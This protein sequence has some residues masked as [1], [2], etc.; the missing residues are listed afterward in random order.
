MTRRWRGASAVGLLAGLA[1]VVSAC[2]GSSES[3]SQSSAAP[4]SASAAASA[5]ASEAGTEATGEPLTI[6]VLNSLTGDL[7]AVGQQ[8]QKGMDLAVDVV[9][10][11]GGINGRPLALEY[12]DDAGSVNQSTQGFKELAASYPV[13]VGPGISA[14]AAAVA[15]LADEYGVTSL[16]IVAQPT[17]A[18]GTK[19]VFTTPPPG[20]ANSQ[21]MVDWAASKGAKTGALIYANNPYGQ[22]GDTAINAA[23]PEAGIEMLNSEGWDPTKFDFTAQAQKVADLNPDVVF[24]YGA[25]G[26][27]D[28][29][30]LKAVVDSGYEGQIVG[31]L[32]SAA[33]FIPETAGNEAAERV[34][35]L[36]AFNPVAPS[37]A[38][39]AFID[40]Y[41][42]KFGEAPS[43]LG[44]YAY[45]AVSLA[46][47]GLAGTADPADGNAVAQTIEGLNFEGA[48]G[49]YEYSPEYR[50]GPGAAAFSAVT[51]KDGQL[52]VPQ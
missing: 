50:G 43:V 6:G 34:V 3:S 1:L 41:T 48:V 38:Q 23:A 35:A 14:Q 40:A 11:A 18:N 37:P 7:G 27:S 8:E 13:I 16:L 46:A 31:D 42:A 28:A 21:A 20:S 26:T 45:D 52:A 29:L 33:P 17:V 22:E 44:L 9:N 30:L 12:I 32:T 10:A 47:A 49:T 25:G 5:A 2:G 39:Q 4:A 19:N 36:T 24:L 51:F 15:P